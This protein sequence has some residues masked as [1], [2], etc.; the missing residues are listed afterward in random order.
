MLQDPLFRPQE[1]LYHLVDSAEDVFDANCCFYPNVFLRLDVN[2]SEKH[3]QQHY[4]LPS[5]HSV[6]VHVFSLPRK[7]SWQN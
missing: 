2:E 6:Q 1:V 5:L 7:Y 4:S 3:S